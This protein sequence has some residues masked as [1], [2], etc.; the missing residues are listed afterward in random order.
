MALRMVNLGVFTK[1][2]CFFSL[3]FMLIVP[4]MPPLLL[5]VQVRINF[6][7]L[8]PHHAPPLSCTQTDVQ[9]QQ[10]QQQCGRHCF[11]YC[12]IITL[13][14]LQRR[15]IVTIRLTWF[16]EPNFGRN[17]RTLLLN[18]THFVSS[19]RDPWEKKNEFLNLSTSVI[20]HPFRQ[21][22][23]KGD[24]AVT[25][26]NQID[27]DVWKEAPLDKKKKPQQQQG[28]LIRRL[29]IHWTVENGEGRSVCKTR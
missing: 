19:L 28:H 18:F 8:P 27:K 14:V 22:K 12:S 29:S 16:K 1:D 26:N 13:R 17:T 4:V 3:S 5:C 9:Q 2:F 24:S 15:A 7:I 11:H 25:Q 23:T 10:L 21:I 20:K 6:Q